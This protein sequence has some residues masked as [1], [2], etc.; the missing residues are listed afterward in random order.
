[1]PAASK[2]LRP[3]KERRQR[4]GPDKTAHAG[5]DFSVK[6]L[7]NHGKCFFYRI[8]PPWAVVFL[9]FSARNPTGFPPRNKLQIIFQE[10]HVFIIRKVAPPIARRRAICYHPRRTRPATEDQRRAG[11]TP[12]PPPTWPENPQQNPILREENKCR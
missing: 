7:K 2:S 11:R 5:N 10:L 12:T 4:R 9:Q 6:N 8:P 3:A 1:M